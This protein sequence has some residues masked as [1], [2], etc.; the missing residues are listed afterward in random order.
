MSSLESA[1]SYCPECNPAERGPQTTRAVYENAALLLKG[2]FPALEEKSAARQTV[3]LLR[4][5][6]GETRRQD[7]VKPPGSKLTRD[8]VL[9]ELL[10]ED[11]AVSS[12]ETEVT[13]RKAQASKPSSSPSKKPR[14][15]CIRLSPIRGGQITQDHQLANGIQI[16][17]QLQ[18]EEL[19]KR[20]LKRESGAESTE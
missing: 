10:D 6:T 14:D 9:A 3:S 7:S 2:S 13:R 11:R 17:P 4:Q 15:L 5:F 20:M 18:P 16:G 19:V 8:D 1:A 12:L